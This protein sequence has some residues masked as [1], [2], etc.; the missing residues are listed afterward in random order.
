VIVFLNHVVI[1]GGLPGPLR[2]ALWSPFAGLQGLGVKIFFVISGF[3]ITSMLTRELD[4]TSGIDTNKF[5]IR[6]SLR[7]FPAYFTFV[8]IV[9]LLALADV[10][11]VSA[12]SVYHALTFGTNF[13]T[14]G[15]D[16]YL[17]HLWSMAVQE[18][19]YFVWPLVILWGGRRSASILALLVAIGIPILRVVNA[20]SA[21]E[22][23]SIHGHGASFDTIAIGCLLAL[24][25]DRLT[26]TR[27]CN[28][29]VESRV[30]IPALFVAGNGAGLIGYRP[31]V[32]VHHT[33]VGI[34]IALGIE[35]CVRHPHGRI[36]TVLN[37]RLMVA[38]GSA[39]FSLYLWQ[40]IFI[41]EQFAKYFPLNVVVA[42][43]VGVASY[44]F[45]ERPVAALWPKAHGLLTA[46]MTSKLRA[47]A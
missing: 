12:T 38:T 41:S 45:I 34:A 47:A 5:L 30:V 24:H 31:S 6:R 33:L 4:Q 17:G 29:L 9:G 13:L 7:I 39:S 27:W 20:T 19:F 28:R 15:G 23:F 14:T 1:V 22:A 3:L 26:S 18:Q 46:P 40:Q 16:W 43:I 32:L 36:G 21:P 37:S 42:V 8:A 44:R 11:P 35:W 2:D 25:R 10:L